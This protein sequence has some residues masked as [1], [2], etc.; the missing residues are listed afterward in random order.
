MAEL[1]SRLFNKNSLKE[2][3][4]IP[5]LNQTRSE[6]I[7]IFNK[8]LPLRNYSSIMAGTNWRNPVYV[9]T[10]ISYQINKL[11][12]PKYYIMKWDDWMLYYHNHNKQKHVWLKT[13]QFHIYLPSYSVYLHSKS[14]EIVPIC[15]FN[16][17]IF[18][19]ICI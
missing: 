5:A 10:K 4:D 1:S 6:K 8:A 16:V 11:L 15:S 19:N 7:Q 12:G 3:Q 18:R 2:L 14:L 9:L 17:H 13:Y